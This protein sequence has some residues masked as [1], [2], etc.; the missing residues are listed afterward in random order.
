MCTDLERQ[1]ADPD[2]F[3]RILRD[4]VPYGERKALAHAMW[5]VVLADG[6]R[7]DLEEA[8]LHEIEAALGLSAEDSAAARAVAL[9]TSD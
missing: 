8:T 3:A 6:E 5:Q 1:A 4:E 2:E 9:G 7:D